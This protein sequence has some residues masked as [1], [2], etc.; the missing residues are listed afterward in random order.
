MCV[1]LEGSSSCVGGILLEGVVNKG[2][3]VFLELGEDGFK[4]RRR[5]PCRNRR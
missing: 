1:Y 4:S 2:E 5:S 3:V